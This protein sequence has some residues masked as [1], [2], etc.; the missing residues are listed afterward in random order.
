[1]SHG[2]IPGFGAL[3]PEIREY[4]DAFIDA[5]V[6]S[7][8]DFFVRDLAHDY[9]NVSR[10][11][12]LRQTTD[13]ILEGFTDYVGNTKLSEH[14]ML[15]EPAIGFSKDGSVAWS[16]FRLKVAGRRAMADGAEGQLDST[17]GCVVLLERRDDR[18]VRIA[19]ASH[20]KPDW[21]AG[22]VRPA[23]PGFQSR[24]SHC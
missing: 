16:I 24:A 6:N 20:R 2:T 14:R 10:G 9:V 3:R 22:V 8:P 1:M 13:E 17:W 4:Y 12:L 18:W 5:R 7:G 21:G 15:S 23:D 19:E 11:E